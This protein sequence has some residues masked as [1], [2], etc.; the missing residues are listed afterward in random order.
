MTT[1][2]HAEQL[3]LV[4]FGGVVLGIILMV[5][6]SD[7]HASAPL[8]EMQECKDKPDAKAY[9][10]R[11]PGDAHSVERCVHMMRHGSPAWVPELG[12]LIP[13][14]SSG[15]RGKPGLEQQLGYVRAECKKLAKQLKQRC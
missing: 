6:I 7:L 13:V 5:S 12:E 2:S 9:M 3:L 15:V 4:G 14:G 10:S 1:M 8:K 11:L